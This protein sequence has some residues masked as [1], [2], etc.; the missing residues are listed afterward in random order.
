MCGWEKI[1]YAC[2]C[3][4]LQKMPYSCDS[5]R[6]HVYGPCQYDPRY[7]RNRVVKVYS[8]LYC[9]GPDCP[10]QYVNY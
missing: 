10:L 6:R 1:M 5:H 2:G 4:K 7:D 3:K 8:D 9:E